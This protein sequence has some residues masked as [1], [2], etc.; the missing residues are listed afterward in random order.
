MQGV[1]AAMAINGYVNDYCF[2]RV[3]SNHI[4]NHHYSDAVFVFQFSPIRDY[5][6]KLSEVLK[7]ITLDDLPT[8]QVDEIAPEDKDKPTQKFFDENM[9]IKKKIYGPVIVGDSFEDF[10]FDLSDIDSLINKLD[11]RICEYEMPD[12]Y[13]LNLINAVWE[14]GK[15]HKFWKPLYLHHRPFIFY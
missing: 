3:D 2:K 11:V 12:A 6:K 9:F 13:T 15:E 5:K 1:R 4:I 8:Y 7:G 10:N 14:Y